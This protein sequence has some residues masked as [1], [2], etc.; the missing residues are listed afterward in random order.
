MMLRALSNTRKVKSTDL[1][2]E[3]DFEYIRT[4]YK[5]EGTE[6]LRQGFTQ[7]EDIEQKIVSMLNAIKT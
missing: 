1:E 2:P 6:N 7:D 4:L 5:I 3:G